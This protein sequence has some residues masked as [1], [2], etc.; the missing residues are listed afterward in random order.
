MIDAAF[1]WYSRQQE[2]VAL[3]ST[4]AGNISL[5]SGAKDKIWTQ[6]LINDTGLVPDVKYPTA[7]STDNQSGIGLVGN[8]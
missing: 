3:S 1:F 5:C 6:S 4:E 8:E 7:M 2:A